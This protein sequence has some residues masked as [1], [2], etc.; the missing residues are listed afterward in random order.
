[1]KFG[2]VWILHSG[3]SEFGFYSLN[4]RVFEFYSINFW[5]IRI[6]QSKVS[7]F[8]S[9]KSKHSQTLRGKVK[10]LKRQCVKFKY[11]KLQGIKSKF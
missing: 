1:M 8:G 11:T 10:I 9:I 6:L 4:F 7:K 5:G 2:G 3:V